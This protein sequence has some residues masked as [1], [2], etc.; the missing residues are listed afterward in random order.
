MLPEDR[1]KTNEELLERVRMLRSRTP[2][3]SPDTAGR[4]HP[5]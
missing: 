5:G 3:A 1:A 4:A 2:G